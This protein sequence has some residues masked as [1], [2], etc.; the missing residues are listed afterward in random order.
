MSIKVLYKPIRKT[1]D[2]FDV[3]FLSAIKILLEIMVVVQKVG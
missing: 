1:F 2:I 3:L